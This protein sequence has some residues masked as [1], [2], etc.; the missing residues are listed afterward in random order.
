M[1]VCVNERKKNLSAFLDQIYGTT[2]GHV[3][4]VTKGLESGQPDVPRWFSWPDDKNVMDA[5]F[6]V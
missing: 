4:V 2:K 1:L 3:C 6:F 5:Y